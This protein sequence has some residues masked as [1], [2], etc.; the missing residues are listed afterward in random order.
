[1]GLQA[2]ITVAIG[3][4]NLIVLGILVPSV[5][6]LVILGTRVTVLEVNQASSGDGDKKMMSEVHEI[7]NIVNSLQIQLA[8]YKGSHLAAIDSVY[9]RI[10][11]IKTEA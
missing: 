7:R 8:E 9:R 11:E 2:W 4:G 10:A 3:A 6:A 1:M 5:K